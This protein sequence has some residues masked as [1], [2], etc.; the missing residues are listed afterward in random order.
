MRQEVA[1][2]REL[3]DLPR[4]VDLETFATALAAGA[5][6]LDV[7]EP[8]EYASGHVPGARPVPLGSLEGAL[9]ELP[10]G[11]AVYVVCATGGRSASAAD[12]LRRAGIEAYSVAG[13]TTGWQASG[14][15]VS[16]GE[17]PR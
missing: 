9:D 4:E 13:G 5:T 6:V 10:A 7:R 11:G 17:L 12:A 1:R 2:Q 3:L 16:A 8:D 14:R 15:E